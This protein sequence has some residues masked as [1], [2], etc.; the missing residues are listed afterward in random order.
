MLKEFRLHFINQN[1]DLH[2]KHKSNYILDSY[3][4]FTSSS[5]NRRNNEMTRNS[6]KIISSVL[7][8]EQ[9]Y[10]KISDIF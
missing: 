4:K 10:I 8:E 5:T 7:T 6:D 9:C 1:K 2:H 3:S